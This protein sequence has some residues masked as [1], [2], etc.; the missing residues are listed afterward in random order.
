MR[1]TQIVTSLPPK[2][3]GVGDYAATLARNLA[4]RY[5]MQTAFV[6]CDPAN[7]AAIGGTAGDRCPVAVLPRR[8]AAALIET[9]RAL[10]S[11]G[12]I[13]LHYVQ[14]GYARKGCPV[15]LWQ[16][17][18]TLCGND[19]ARALVTMFHELYAPGHFPDSAFWLAP[20]QKVLARRIARLSRACVTSREVYARILSG[21]LD[22]KAPIP[23]SLPVPSGV[24]EG[25]E[26]PDFRTRRREMIV[27]GQGGT[28]AQAY[29]EFAPDLE[30]ACRHLG[31]EKIIDIGPE[32]PF[33]PETVGGIPVEAH[34]R[35]EWS[36][37]RDLLT[38][39]LAGFLVYDLAYL[40]RSSVFAAYCT[41]GLAPVCVH[42]FRK[43]RAA[44]RVR[45]QDGLQSGI[46]FW[47]NLP[48]A[49][50]P[51]EPVVAE[52]VAAAARAWY[53]PHDQ[54]A[55]AASFHALMQ[56]YAGPASSAHPLESRV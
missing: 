51:L 43:E 7:T 36:A 50:G 31:I 14:Y 49:A 13:L 1:I 54:A 12:P 44:N 26:P 46:H 2:V 25:G 38:N 16:G 4:D 20:V 55:H 35:L 40:G 5:G 30:R 6:V 19:D 10:A 23:E 39:A 3:D 37:I 11:E 34:G 42:V 15:W 22:G 41:Y 8:S 28:R 56:R 45:W 53:R 18:R 29:G 33:L 9:T 48:Y 24:G 52:R 47:E 21:W 27:F 17:L 32:L